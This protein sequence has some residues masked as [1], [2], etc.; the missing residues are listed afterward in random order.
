M[1]ILDMATADRRAA[2]TQRRNVPIV[3]CDNFGQRSAFL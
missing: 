2:A 3:C 1:A